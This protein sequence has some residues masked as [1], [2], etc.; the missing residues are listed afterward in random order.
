MVSFQDK[1]KGLEEAY[2]SS[3]LQHSPDEEKIKKIL[4][5]CLEEYYG[6]LE[7]VIESQDHY[8]SICKHGVSQQLPRA[9]NLCALNP[10]C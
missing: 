1:E 2:L 7:G 4:L 9:S 3:K 6:S 10:L 8:K 5:E